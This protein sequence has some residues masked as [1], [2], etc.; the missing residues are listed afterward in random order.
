MTRLGRLCLFVAVAACLT[1]L[2]RAE[3]VDGIKGLASR[4]FGHADD[5][6]FVLT[7]QN[8]PWSRWNIPSNDSYAVNPS[9]NDG[10][11]RIEGST[12]SALARG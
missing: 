9:G 7:R 12:L 11:I 3:S 4:I 6:D 8:E 1:A 5:F 2:A 10:K